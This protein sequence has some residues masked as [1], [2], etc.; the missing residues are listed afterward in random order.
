[1]AWRGLINKTNHCGY[2]YWSSLFLVGHAHWSNLCCGGWWSDTS[3][4]T[5]AWC[6]QNRKKIGG[7]HAT[8]QVGIVLMLTAGFTWWSR[9]PYGK[10]TIPFSADLV[11]AG[12]TSW[13]W[14]TI[15]KSTFFELWRTNSHLLWILVTGHFPR[16][17]LNIAIL[18]PLRHFWKNGQKVCH[19][20]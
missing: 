15:R 20:P 7:E 17:V 14:V 16:D 8:L 5:V 3:W 11:G 1:M 2:H 4:D 19:P 13:W 6:F 12:S 18:S 9:T 10:K